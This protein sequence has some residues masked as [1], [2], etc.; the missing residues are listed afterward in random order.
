MTYHFE[1]TLQHLSVNLC[2][3]AHSLELPY[4][5]GCGKESHLLPTICHSFV[6]TS[7]SIPSMVC[8]Y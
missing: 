6:T 7:F 1:Y 8:C 5:V 3:D 2:T 4:W